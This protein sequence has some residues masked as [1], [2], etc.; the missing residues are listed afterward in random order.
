MGLTATCWMDQ[1][2]AC[3]TVMRAG[4]HY[5][6]FTL[7][8]GGFM[9]LGVVRPKWDAASTSK[10]DTREQGGHCFFHTGS[11]QRF[12]GRRK[13]P[14]KRKWPGV[15]RARATE[16]DRIGLL[17]DLEKGSMAV[18]KNDERLGLMVTSGLHGEFCW[19]IG[20]AT[21]GHAVRIQSLPAPSF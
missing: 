3:G 4:R 14:G 10:L 15:A 8:K 20:I 2:A 6:Q 17:L 11:G 12:S 21:P 9:M 7:V 18:Y 13:P 16:G 5:A 1:T 19:A